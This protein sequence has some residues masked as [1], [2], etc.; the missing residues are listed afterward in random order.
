MSNKNTDKKSDKV[1]LTLQV[2]KH[3]RDTFK[4]VCEA[5]DSTVSRE[6]RFFMRKYINDSN[7]NGSLI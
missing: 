7:N 1:M 6:I 3:L 4:K 2:D 5:N